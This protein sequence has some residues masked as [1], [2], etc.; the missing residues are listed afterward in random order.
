MTLANALEAMRLPRVAGRTDAHTALVTTRPL[1]RPAPQALGCGAD[2]WA[3]RS[4]GRV[5]SCSPTTGC[6]SWMHGPSAH[7]TSWKACASP[8]RR[9]FYEYHLPHVLNLRTFAGLAE[10]MMAMR[11]LDRAQ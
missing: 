5:T 6:S 11:D 1:T 8:S 9:V 7:A 4:C 2:Q 3:A 10:R